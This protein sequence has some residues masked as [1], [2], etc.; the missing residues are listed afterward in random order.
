MK[1]FHG[2]NVLIGAIDLS[3]SQQGKDFG[4]GFYLN[5]SLE[6]AS[7][8]AKRVTR[9]RGC[10]AA[11][12][13]A[14]E[15]DEEALN[16]TSLRVLRFE[17]YT[18]EWLDFIVSNRTGKASTGEPPYDIVIGPIADDT[19]GVSLSLLLRGFITPDEALRRLRYEGSQ[20]VQYFFATPRAVSLLT[21][22]KQ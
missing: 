4:R 17:G 13:T 5:P 18:P 9:S 15:L 21:H 2:S 3:L 12:I 16:D 22:A 14:F 6:Q 7:A 11:S 8:M 20:A 1:L 19:V 10:G